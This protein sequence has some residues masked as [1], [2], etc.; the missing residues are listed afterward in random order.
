MMKIMG[1]SEWSYLGSYLI[2]HILLS[3]ITVIAGVIALD[4]V[5]PETSPFL[6]FMLTLLYSLS[7]FGFVLIGV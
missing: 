5:Y 4:Y 7:L 3:I 1:L 2:N 6:I